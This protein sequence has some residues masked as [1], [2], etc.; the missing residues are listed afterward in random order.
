MKKKVT[1]STKVKLVS[2]C[3]IIFFLCCLLSLSVSIQRSIVAVKTSTSQKLVYTASAICSQY[4]EL[5]ESKLLTLEEAQKKT[6][7]AIKN[8]Q[9][10]QHE[11][12]LLLDGTGKMI[13]EPDRPELEGTDVGSYRDS[14]GKAVFADMITI[15]K[16]KGEGDIDYYF[17]KKGT[18][19]PVKKFA[20]V[21]MFE[22]WG[23]VLGTG[24]YLDDIFNDI[25]KTRNMALSMIALFSVLVGIVFFWL[26]R[27]VAGPVNKAAHGLAQIGLELHSAAQQFSESSQ[28]LAQASSEQAAALEETSSSLEEL[29]SM[30]RQNADNASQADMLTKEASRVIREAGDWMLELT[31]SM[32]DISR[33]SEEISVINKTIDEIAFQTNLLALN[34][35]VE[36]ARAG[37][38]GA[39]FAVVADEVRNLAMR[40]TTASKSTADLIETTVGK[41]TAGAELMN[42]T[43]QAFG[44][45]SDKSSRVAQLVAEI[46]AATQEQSQGIAQVSRVVAEMDRVTQSNS[47]NAEE[48]ASGSEEIK[49][50]ADHMKHYIDELRSMIG[51]KSS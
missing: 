43:N 24:F 51:M 33:S 32:S 21:K 8:M 31:R 44:D 34:A 1:L 26:G 10:N 42:R 12:F 39:G 6:I 25:A 23:W 4:N 49:Y 35:A 22:P 40:S 50:K 37:E 13:V 9:H 7:L 45:V 16:S 2:A 5:V 17:Q 3:F 11:G 14:Q 36:A 29:S 28:V 48:S 15:C 47:A 18:D 46:A 41:I 20:Y 30:T 38:A 19:T 27:A